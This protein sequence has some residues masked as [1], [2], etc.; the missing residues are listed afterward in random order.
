[1]PKI[2]LSKRNIAFISFGLTICILLS[3]SLFLFS[4]PVLSS[5]YTSCEKSI[6][7]SQQI[8]ITAHREQSRLLGKGSRVFVYWMTIDKGNSWKEF[9]KFYPDEPPS[10]PSCE[11]IKILDEQNFWI[12]EGWQLGITHDGGKTWSL[13]K[14][15]DT[16]QDWKCCNFDFITDVQFDNPSIGTM[17]LDFEG[18]GES[19]TTVQTK[20]GGKTW[21]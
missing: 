1:M 16:W 17:I 14:A 10:A 5:P 8:K 2:Y 19:F 20:D 6:S 11:T 13:W 4:A 7:D 9:M 12:W 21:K 18:Y 3:V 15:T